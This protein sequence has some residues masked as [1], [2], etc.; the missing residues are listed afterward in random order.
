[1]NQ[2]ENRLGCRR[3]NQNLC[4]GK[5]I[6]RDALI[7]PTCLGWIAAACRAAFRTFA[8]CQCTGDGGKQNKHE[9]SSNES[10]HR[11]RNC[12][13]MTGPRKSSLKPSPLF[14]SWMSAFRYA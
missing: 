10:L 5:E 4:D 1:M 6:S 3:Y 14:F 7:A 13:E 2:N 9:V 8:T 12:M 11:S